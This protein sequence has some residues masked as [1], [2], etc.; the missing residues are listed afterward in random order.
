[1]V[2]LVGHSFFDKHGI[3][4]NGHHTGD[5]F[6]VLKILAAIKQ[7]AAEIILFFEKQHITALC[8]HHS[9]TVAAK[10]SISSLLSYGPNN[11]DYKISG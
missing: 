7:T 5:I 9:P 11:V 2:G 1:V 4:A 6:T 8:M 10:L 3:K